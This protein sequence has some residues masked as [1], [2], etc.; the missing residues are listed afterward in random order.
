MFNS[1]GDVKIKRFN[2]N[3][4]ESFKRQYNIKF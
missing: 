3:Q 1:A 2:D 4:F